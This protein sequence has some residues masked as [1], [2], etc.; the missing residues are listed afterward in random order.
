M[1]MPR[2]PPPA[3]ALMM[4]GKPISSARRVAS[5]RSSMGP[6][7]PGTVGTPARFMRSLALILSPMPSMTS[8]LGPMNLR[9]WSW[10]ICAKRAFS[11]KKP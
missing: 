10:Q 3:A 8:A 5:A 6:S 4:T 2:P 1:R 9:P 11:A 7:V